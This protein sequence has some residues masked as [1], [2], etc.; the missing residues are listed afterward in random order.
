MSRMILTRLTRQALRLAA[1]R[2]PADLREELHREWLAELA[3]LEG[4][5]GTAGRRLGFAISLLTSPPVRDAAGVPRG[6]AEA[7]PALSP[8]AA[9]MLTALFGIGVVGLTRSLLQLVFEASGRE[10][11]TWLYF[12]GAPLVS[13]VFLVLWCVPM[14]R[15]LGRRLPMARDGRL[16][17]AGPAVLAPLAV[18]PALL[19]WG[20]GE[21]QLLPHPTTAIGAVA[22]TVLIALLGAAAARAG[23]PAAT[24]LVLGGVP[25]VAVVATVLATVP[26]LLA[27]GLDAGLASLTMSFDTEVLRP[28]ES[29]LIVQ[30]GALAGPFLAYGWLAVVYGRRAA[31]A[32]DRPIRIAEPVTA[33]E[34]VRAGLPGVTLAAG[35]TAVLTGVLAWAYTITYLTPAMPVMSEAAPM[36]GGDGEIYL[37]VAELRWA[38]ILLTA[39]GVLVATADR[40]SAPRAALVVAVGLLAAESV[41]LIQDV[42][43]MAGLRI[44]LLVAAVVIALG[45]ALA[46]RVAPAATR[47]RTTA[48]A[49]AAAGLGPLLFG[50]GTPPENH[51]FMPLGLPVTT[52]GV[53]VVMVLLG[54][55]TAVTTS[56]YRLHPVVIALLTVVPTVI[57]AGLGAYLGNGVSDR[58]SIYGVVL[59]L[60]LA[61]LVT[62]VLRRH[63]SRRRGRTTALWGML[64][65]VAVPSTIAFYLAAVMPLGFVAQILF[66]IDGTGY[67]ADGLSVLP[68][69]ALLLLPAAFVLAGRAGG[70]PVGE[71]LPAPGPLPQPVRGT[72]G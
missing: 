43:G 52:T 16:G 6:W 10:V 12:E 32:P 39:L 44:A 57:L 2:W 17:V 68:G 3:H 53:A 36:P 42:T 33:E 22:W 60:P 64:T 18:L 54:T 5:P 34:T 11:S 38:A 35:V 8:A 67:P 27:Q 40:R 58:T 20:L 63:R 13:T 26:V 48:A 61:V 62:A 4:R 37:W 55:V 9:L 19:V 70:A 28:D 65:V 29:G 1:R 59:S 49:I 23:R 7:R 66:T 69:A 46:G 47:T 56:R 24:A 71:A 31:H 72:S 51:P 25:A 50:Q 21:G 30:T 14:G 45:W 41:L 15:W